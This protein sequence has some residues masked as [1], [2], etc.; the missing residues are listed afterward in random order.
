M[1]VVSCSVIAARTEWL[2]FP[3]NFRYYRDAPALLYVFAVEYS[4]VVMTISVSGPW[5]EQRTQ[6]ISR[7]L[8]VTPTLSNVSRRP[9][10]L[11]G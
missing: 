6:A 4:S 3:A 8:P 7:G 11:P 1:I 9:H 10:P 5:Q 2:G